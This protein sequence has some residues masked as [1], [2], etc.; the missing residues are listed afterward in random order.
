MRPIFLAGSEVGKFPAVTYQIPKLAN[1]CR[2]DEAPGDEV[3]LEDVGNPL[4]VPLV[5]FL[6][7]NGFH[8]FGVGEDNVTGLLQ[9]IV[10]GNPVL[11][12]RFH[13]HIFAV[14]LSQSGSAA[15]QI[16]GKG[17]EPLALV[18]GHALLIGRSDAGNDE[19]LVDIHP[20]ADTVNNFKHNTSP[21][22]SI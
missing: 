11:S 1:I 4:G 14:V 16:S 5:R 22:N 8:I 15:V 13:A 9:N 12:G 7:P 2:W 19:G 10:D 6:T 3:V 17:G 21:Q 20:A 18:G